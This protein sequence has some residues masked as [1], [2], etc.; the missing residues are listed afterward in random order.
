MYS[1]HTTSLHGRVIVKLCILCTLCSMALALVNLE[2]QSSWFV[3]DLVYLCWGAPIV[4]RV[5][6]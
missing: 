3:L 4:L 5:L 6:R 2:Q 1:V